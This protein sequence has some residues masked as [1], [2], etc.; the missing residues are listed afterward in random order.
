M[1]KSKKEIHYD[2]FVVE[3]EKNKSEMQE[4]DDFVEFLYENNVEAY[5]IKNI[6][7]YYIASLWQ[8]S[9]YQ[10]DGDKKIMNKNKKGVK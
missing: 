3:T 4:V 9:Y 6:L 7:T 8:L 2:A 1:A 5:E 10:R